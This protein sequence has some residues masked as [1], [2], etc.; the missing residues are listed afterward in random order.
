[1]L[2]LGTRIEENKASPWRLTVPPFFAGSPLVSPA[3]V[4]AVGWRKGLA[5]I[6]SQPRSFPNRLPYRWN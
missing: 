3:A 2:E 4:P 6:L 1:M 5:R